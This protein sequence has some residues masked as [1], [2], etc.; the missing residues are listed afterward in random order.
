M[1]LQQSNTSPREYIIHS[2]H[3]ISAGRCKFVTCAVEASVK[4]LIIVSPECL[5]ALSCSNIP[6]TGG[7]VD[8]SCETVVSCEVKL[9]ARELCSVPFESMDALAGTNIPNFR[10]VIKRGS[11]KFVTVSV[12]VQRNNL[13]SVAFQIKNLLTSFYVP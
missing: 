10:S 3:S 4:H 8:T 1:P 9:A 12:E 11:H 2:S 7:S 5:N 6:Q 13:S